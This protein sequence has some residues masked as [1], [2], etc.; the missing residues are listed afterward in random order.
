MA[1]NYYFDNSCMNNANHFQR[2]W[3]Q[4]AKKIYKDSSDGGL[5]IKVR[6]KKFHSFK[7][8]ILAISSGKYKYTELEPKIIAVSEDTFS[9]FLVRGSV[10]KI[11][12]NHTSGSLVLLTV[13]NEHA[14][15]FL[16]W[17]CFYVS[18]D[19]NS[20]RRLEVES[21]EYVKRTDWT[22]MH[23]DPTEPE[24]HSEGSSGEVTITSESDTDLLLNEKRSPK[25]KDIKIKKLIEENERQKMEN[26]R[27][28]AMLKKFSG[29]LFL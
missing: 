22:R 9:T 8:R 27:L 14:L 7:Y 13:K 11:Q 3:I 18:T 21:V 20:S 19:T 2:Y 4:L 25:S 26:E 28:K 29:S 23:I 15:Q 6:V 24:I 10:Q 16:F 12:R 17:I 1:I 5:R